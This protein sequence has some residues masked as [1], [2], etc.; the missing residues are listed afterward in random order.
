MTGTAPQ[1]VPDP[2]ARV[3]DVVRLSTV[4]QS[5]VRWLW[6]ARFPMGK[7]SVL[8]G[9]P[10]GG[11]TFVM[12]YA[13]A[14]VSRGTAWDDVPGSAREPGSVVFVTLEDDP[15]DTIRPRIGAHGGNLDHVYLIR[16]SRPKHGWK[17][18]EPEDVLQLPRDIAALEFVIREIGDVRLV[19]VDPISGAIE[20]RINQNSDREVREALA[21][22]AELANRTGTAVVCV[23]HL[24]KA[25]DVAAIQRVQGASA[26]GALARSVW[27]VVRDKADPERR[28]LACLKLSVGKPA[29][30]LAFTIDGGQILWAG[31]VEDADPETLLDP[32]AR[33]RAGRDA[34]GPKGQAAETFLRDSLAA[35]PIAVQELMKR[36]AEAGLKWPTV[37]KARERLGVLADQTH[38]GIGSAW[39]WRMPIATDPDIAATQSA[40]GGRAAA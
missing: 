7:L 20:G 31:E 14:C 19:V 24:R 26:F 25:G 17:K 33:P 3:L 1:L 22:L 29:P 15:A 36:A 16:G 32:K 12:C 10:G 40:E 27:T 9:V 28:I 11:K 5:V 4:R 34:M 18:T 38:R 23:A 13:A 8:A 2:G 39:Q 21:G 30:A 6:P 37:K 35:G